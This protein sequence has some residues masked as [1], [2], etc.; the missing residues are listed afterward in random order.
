MGMGQI[1][2]IY[3]P[4]SVVSCYNH[5]MSNDP[6][7]DV[8]FHL[9]PASVFKAVLIL[10][11]AAVLFF[12]LD[13]VL[14]ILVAVLIASAIEPV[15]RWLTRRRVPRLLSVLSIY[16]GILAVL[17]GVF[18]F[19]LLPLV[20]DITGFF[21]T[22]PEY[23]SELEA[24]TPF[25]AGDLENGIAGNF[26]LQD[27]ISQ[28]NMMFADATAGIF[29]F[30]SAVSGGVLGFI[31]I[32]VLSFYLSVQENGVAKFLRAI[33]P[34]R[35]EEYVLDLWSRAE[36]KIGYWAQGQ[37]ILALLVGV[38]V[39]LSLS[40]LGVPYALLLAVLAAIFELIPIFG[41]ILAAIPA[42]IVAFVE[43]GNF[44]GAGLEMAILVTVVYIIIQQIESQVIYPLLF[45]KM[46]EV[47]PIV[48]IISLVA[49]FQL[50]GFLGVII[51]VPVAAIIVELFKDYE[52]KKMADTPNAL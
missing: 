46:V 45:K 20:R 37:I 4:A 39:Y 9:S 34:R 43:G 47:S 24:W 10:A 49:G 12:L 15:T 2:R 28:I 44:F 32:L 48:I 36:K 17:T 6:Q 29:T 8:T 23:I 1:L 38:L 31:L 19:L 51:S 33:T 21:R 40:I 22:L 14:V 5:E 27:I 50:L 13:L 7:R 26:T 41:P 25:V 30:L 42:V 18:Y 35:H 16:F 3:Y 52:K 11:L